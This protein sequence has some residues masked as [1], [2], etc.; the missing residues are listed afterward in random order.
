MMRILKSIYF[1]GLSGLMLTSLAQ[2]SMAPSQRNPGN[3]PDHEVPQLIV[4]GSDDNT[5]AEAMRWM[6]NEL[7]SRTH[8]DGTPLRMSF[9]SNTRSWDRDTAL[10]N[11]HREAYAAKH[12]LGN[13]TRDHIHHIEREWTDDGPVVTKI[14]E[15][16]E[17][18]T[19]QYMPVMEALTT[20]IGV[21]PKHIYGF[22]TPFLEFTNTTFTGLREIGIVYDCSI[23]EGA[24]RS[25][26][27]FYWPYTMDHQPPVLPWWAVSN[28]IEVT[29][30]PGLWQL[31]AYNF[32]VPEDIH[33]H[34]DTM[35]TYDHGG[36]VSGLD[37][38]M[39]A[40][41]NAGGFEFNKDQSLRTLKRTLNMKY[42]GNRTPFTFGAH[43]QMYF[44]KNSSYVNIQDPAERQAMF[45][46]FLDYALGYDNV[47]FV[48]GAQVIN[49]MQQPV[50]ASEFNPGDY[51]PQNFLEDDEET[52]TLTVT[53]GTGSGEF[54]TGRKITITA[55]APPEG[56]RFK[57]WTGD[58]DGIE[59]VT[60]PT[61]TITIGS[62]N[63]TVTAT[64]EELGD[65]Y[66]KNT[67]NIATTAYWSPAADEF[68]STADTGDA[69][70]INDI[71]TMNY[72]IAPMEPETENWTW[73]SFIA[74]FDNDLSNLNKVRITYRSAAA[75]EIALDQPPLSDA[76]TSY[77]AQ[78]PASSDWNT[79]EVSIDEFAQP[80]W[81]DDADLDLSVVVSISLSPVIADYEAGQAG[82][83][84][85][86]ELVF[87]GVTWDNNSVILST[88]GQRD[89]NALSITGVN[90]AALN[91]DVPT[92]GNY[93]IS[94]HSI[95]G[96]LIL[97]DTR[98]FTGGTNSVNWDV[99]KLSAQMYI[100]SI[101]G[102]GL[103]TSRRFHIAR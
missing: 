71:A 96:S 20:Q 62:S 78:I 45:T 86:K 57:A 59:D 65:D 9:Y 100:V 40:R 76:G 83:I 72:D 15:L 80:T 30:H 48:S 46:E 85:V 11:A 102:N 69:V 74:S 101:E 58:V 87:Y 4:I 92:S 103:R 68:G 64:Y 37:Y 23:M 70:L 98:R 14:W 66:F 3:F 49:Y 47:W 73:V 16:D 88:P 36:I 18:L 90:A 81:A 19:E 79:V 84:E 63:V 77:K 8:K 95:N 13:H 61:T 51:L 5:D 67:G 94:V 52:F 2:V 12:S 29:S 41:R 17:L 97:R 33:S 32:S 7:A 10:V 31:P 82:T 26:G 50:R 25:P 54:A 38:N 42:N 91:V 55:G 6:L 43:S 39:W 75:L 89:I 22:R 1:L 60:S 93:T 21:N 53:N 24:G 27:E 34:M 35:V 99:S 56:H 44:G 28:D